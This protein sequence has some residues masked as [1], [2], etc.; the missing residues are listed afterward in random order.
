MKTLKVTLPI[1]IGFLYLG[2][3]IF[4]QNLDKGSTKSIDL[5]WGVKIPLRD[6]IKLNATVYKPKGAGPLPVI[7]T[8]T[9]YI[10]DSYHNRAYYFSQN[11]YVFVLID[12]R[13]RG[14]SE[15]TFTPLLQEAKDGYDVVEWLSKQS[16]CNEKVAMWGGSYAGYDQ[17]ATA[18]EFPSNLKTI[19]PV[20]SPMALV[21]FPSWRNIPNSY[22]M[23]WL[24]YVSGVTPNSNLFG[25]SSFWIKKFSEIYINHLPFK[26][27]DKII[28]NPS[29]IF[30]TWT[31]HPSQ[32]DY[33]VT[34]N[35]TNE[36]FSRINI[37]I[38][39]ITGIYDADQ[40][41]A[42]GNYKKH[43]MFASKEAKDQHYLI[44]GPWDHAG[45]RTPNKEVGGLTFGDAS[46]LDM[47]K[48]HKDWYDWVFKS[49]NK[50]DFL[51]NRIAYYVTGKEVWKYAE[52]L[53][54]IS[55][56]QRILYLDSEPII[57][58]DVFHSGYLSETKPMK[59]PSDKFV[60]D[61]LD[62]RPIELDTVEV[63]N[64]LTDQRHAQ[65]LFGNGLVYHTEPFKE[66]TEISG[67]SK[68]NLWISMDVPDTD[69]EV[70]LYEIKT[71][72]SSVFLTN[73]LL[74]A[75]YRESLGEQKLIEPGAILK[76]DFNGF[77]WFS[78]QIAKG[79]RL[80]LVIKC[81]NTLYLQK[82]YN[83]GKNVMEETGKDAHTAHITVYHDSK[84]PSMLE[85]PIVK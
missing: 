6:G 79:S 37:P 85:L 60:Y 82:N 40:P 84:Y 51:K 17:W 71:D 80:R 16:W 33:W 22:L 49:A 55:T 72:G 69:F 7:F 64:Y 67:Y 12:A 53:E 1:L 26:D 46:Q 24:T 56:E 65:N 29:S 39:S 73:D 54:S 74:R 9:P 57:V 61:P 10:A 38:L 4:G 75:R 25:E 2:T 36:Q 47:N 27:L 8:L 3:P 44:I 28:G 5:M 42:M 18:K 35:P 21:D 77:F 48:L 19:V 81:S 76:Y 20:A 11:G 15:G 43:M 70:N 63:D 41:G 14:N 30:Q 45:T 31:S 32:S 78:R 23:Q 58:N 83:S 62:V 59:S 34:Y 68:L 13:G 50:P 66:N 52:S